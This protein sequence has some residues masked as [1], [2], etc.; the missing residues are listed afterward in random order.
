MLYTKNTTN[1]NNNAKYAATLIG[2]GNALNI[3]GIIKIS[4]V[5]KIVETRADNTAY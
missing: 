2:F 5:A 4:K 3:I 1:G